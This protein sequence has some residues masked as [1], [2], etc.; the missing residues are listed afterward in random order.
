[1]KSLPSLTSR[2]TT[3]IPETD[4]R[5]LSRPKLSVN[6]KA[7]LPCRFHVKNMKIMYS[8]ITWYI[9]KK[10]LFVCQSPFNMYVTYMHTNLLTLHLSCATYKGDTKHE[11]L[12][13]T[14]SAC[15]YMYM[16]THMHKYTMYILYCLIVTELPSL[17]LWRKI[18]LFF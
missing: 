17:S 14:D 2:V 6:R 7:C 18:S 12:C 13:H 15:E 1:M 9:Y 5:I 4:F 11:M 8:F 10:N 16:Y 3:A